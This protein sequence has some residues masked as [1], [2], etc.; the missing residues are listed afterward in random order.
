MK[1]YFAALSTTALISVT[2]FALAASST[3]LTVTGLITP[4]ACT[5]SLSNNGEIDLGKI[6]A[7][8]LKPD[9]PTSLTPQPLQLIVTCDAS[10]A[11]ALEA[12]DTGGDTAILPGYFGLGMTPA[13]ERI[14]MFDIEIKT[15]LADAVVA[16]AIGSEDG[17]TTWKKQNFISY[18]TLSSVAATSDHSTRID[19]K[20][21]TME[22][23]IKPMIAPANSL[24]LTEEIAI[25]GSASIEV[26]YL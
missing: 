3:D 8:D 26:T 1:K 20:D 12:S 19:V 5:P 17:G 24:T 10:T 9:L 21:L 7:K 4:A 14:G 16:Q 18:H 25:N 2:P 22:L 23:Q 11:L 6:P 13:N 15:T